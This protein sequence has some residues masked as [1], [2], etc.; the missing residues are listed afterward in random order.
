MAGSY[1][2]VVAPSGD[3]VGSATLTLYDVPPDPVSDVSPGGDP[4]SVETTVPG[5]D[6]ALTFSGTAGERVSRVVANPQGLLRQLAGLQAHTRQATKALRLL[7]AGLQH[8]IEADI[9]YRD[10]FYALGTS[11][12]PLPPNQSCTLA[13]QSDTRA[14]TAKQ[15]FV[16]AYNPIAKRVGRRT[17]SATEI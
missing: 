13:R 9:R 12:C 10:G 17:W 7:R 3:S 11:G 5:Q 2:V 1:R 16:A 4:I 14:S 15:Q 8:S 6:A